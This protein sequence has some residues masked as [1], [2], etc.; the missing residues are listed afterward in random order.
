[1]LTCLLN[2]YILQQFLFYI[3]KILSNM[4]N[5][6]KYAFESVFNN[7]HYFIPLNISNFPII[8]NTRLTLFRLK[9]FSPKFFTKKSGELNR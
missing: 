8:S 3:K 9:N 1:M 5:N 4:F 2:P 7:K 6:L